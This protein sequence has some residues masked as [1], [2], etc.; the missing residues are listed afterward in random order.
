MLSAVGGASADPI[1]TP[2]NPL[3]PDG[4]TILHLFGD[5]LFDTAMLQSHDPRILEGKITA[6]SVLCRVISSP[7]RRTQVL[8]Q[9]LDR[10]YATI[11]ECTRTRSALQA[12]LLEGELLIAADLEGSGVLLPD[13]ISALRC[14]LPWLSRELPE[15]RL[16]NYQTWRLAALR[17]LTSIICLPSGLASMPLRKDWTPPFISGMTPN[18]HG[19]LHVLNRIRDMYARQG[20]TTGNT[21]TYA[22]LNRPIVEM[23]LASIANEKNPFSFV[24]LVRLAQAHVMEDAGATKGLA[25]VVVKTILDKVLAE[26]LSAQGINAGFETLTDLAEW[27]KQNGCV[28][29][30]CARQVILSVCRMIQA[31][32]IKNN[33]D[34]TILHGAFECLFRWVSSSRQLIEDPNMYRAVMQTL[35]HSLRINGANAGRVSQ[36]AGAANDS[37]VTQRMKRDIKRFARQRASSQTS[38][39]MAN[40]AT[41]AITGTTSYATNLFGGSMIVE[42]GQEGIMLQWELKIYLRRFMD[43]ISHSQEQLSIHASATAAAALDDLGPLRRFV[44]EHRQSDQTNR[45]VRFV[46]VD[47]RMIVGYMEVPASD[48]SS[49]CAEHNDDEIVLVLR[50]VMGKHIHHARSRIADTAFLQ[51][52]KE[53]NATTGCAPKYAPPPANGDH[54]GAAPTSNVISVHAANEGCIP[55]FDHMFAEGSDSA[56][57]AEMV[58]RLVIDQAER[59][60]CNANMLSPEKLRSMYAQ[61]PK[62]SGDADRVCTFRQFVTQIGYLRHENRGD[63]A[64]LPLTHKLLDTLASF[65]RISTR[66]Q[67]GVSMYYAQTQPTTKERLIDPEVH[68]SVSL[69][70]DRF[71]RNLG[72]KVDVASH[73]GFCGGLNAQN[74]ATTLYYACDDAEIVFHVPYLIH[75]CTATEEIT[76]D[77]AWDCFRTISTNDVLACL[78]V[79]ND[80]AGAFEFIGTQILSERS[81][82]IGCIL[83]KPL[84]SLSGLYWLRIVLRH[85]SDNVTSSFG[86]LI[87]GMI[88]TARTLPLLIRGAAIHAQQH[89]DTRRDWR[90]EPYVQRHNLLEEVSRNHALATPFNEFFKHVFAD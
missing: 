71:L 72:D 80:P 9:H 84:S 64:V 21:G 46:M 67:I 82:T 77:D 25:P 89:R 43:L 88:A 32:F 90:L 51:R 26:E 61:A 66:Q 1:K 62:A 83:I 45:G 41:S 10:F 39:T 56:R 13:L 37:S 81:Q 8:R 63:V 15:T 52:R 50:D 20:S 11:M 79:Q 53:M 35:E 16:A 47:H 17:L 48:H 78:W 73:T 38:A 36:N 23:V 40:L 65:D 49:A 18:S 69:E 42:P 7:Q 75:G 70:F 57:A 58:E 27:C 31:V 2:G 55:A 86:P 44:D 19:E 54:A 76:A 12:I 30:E 60:T 68:G 74:A 85:N 87:N 24:R 22:D 3:P 4:N 28:D 6:I 5:W 34:F 29:L 59:E 14:M 33:A